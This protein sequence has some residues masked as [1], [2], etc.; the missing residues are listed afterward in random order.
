MRTLTHPPMWEHQET[1]VE[2]VLRSPD[3]TTSDVFKRT[4]YKD[5]RANAPTALSSV[6]TAVGAAFGAAFSSTQRYGVGAGLWFDMRTGKTRTTFEALKRA[7][8]RLTLVVAPATV[9]PV[10]LDEA[11][12]WWSQHEDGPRMLLLDKSAGTEVSRVELLKRHLADDS[13]LIV[14]LNYEVVWRDKLFDVLSKCRWN[15]IV[16]DEVHRIKDHG[17]RASKAMWQLGRKA[18]RRIGLSGTPMPHNALDAF[19]VMRFVDE[20]VFGTVYGRFRTRY[21]ITWG[22]YN[23]YVSGVR[24]ADDIARRMA[25]HCMVVKASDVLD[26]PK[27]MD[28]TINVDLPPKMRKA[29]DS[30]EKDLIAEIDEGVVTASNALTKL[31]R[32]QQITSGHIPITF[33]TTEEDII[34]QTEVVEF[35]EQPKADALADLIDGM[36]KDAP[37][38][39]FYLFRKDAERIQEIVEAT[40]TKDTPARKF[41]HIRGGQNDSKGWVNDTGGSVLIAQIRSACEGLPLHRANVCI[42]YSTGFNNGNYRQSRKRT[43]LPGKKSV[44]YYHLV[45]RGSVDEKIIK[46]LQKGE[47][48]IESCIRQMRG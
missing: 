36:D 41:F 7:K 6:G 14:V 4:G 25:P 33:A 34:E 22:P 13:P 18:E 27:E 3:E 40:G 2:L 20:T 38:I 35:E 11:D 10:W 12:K 15:F 44:T 26:M 5:A 31:L 45:A 42:Y 1:G 30:L 43:H 46:A 29:Y 28:V 16:A 39:V 17:G 24:D 32:L 21:A 48:A 47:D 9:C 19:A 23:S 8:P 37:L